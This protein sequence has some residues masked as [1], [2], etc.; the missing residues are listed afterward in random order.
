VATALRGPVRL[1]IGLRAMDAQTGLRERLTAALHAAEPITG[2]RYRAHFVLLD[3]PP[4]AWFPQEPGPSPSG[5]PPPPPLVN[6]PAIPMPDAV[7][8]PH[9]VIDGFLA[10]RALDLQ[11]IP[12]LRQ[13]RFAPQSLWRQGRA[14]APG[15][16][17]IQAGLPLLRVPMV[18]ALHP[19]TSATGS[20]WTLE[21]SDAPLSLLAHAFPAPGGPLAYAPFAGDPEA[22]LLNPV[23]QPLAGAT[24]DPALAVGFGAMLARTTPT[25]CAPAFTS[26]STEGAL[27]RALSWV[28]SPPPFQGQCG[29]P[30][31]AR[32]GVLL[33]VHPWAIGQSSTW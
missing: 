28:R 14:Y 24:L 31:N 19:H 26:A 21:A 6:D 20:A 33:D 32:F 23:S 16:G 8:L 1:T 4:V 5:P 15:R 3:Q 29:G 22:G 2:T 12:A 7:L 18:C 25:D 27:L 30:V 10:V 13:A 11:P 17:T 9:D